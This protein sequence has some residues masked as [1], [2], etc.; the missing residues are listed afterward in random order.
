MLGRCCNLFVGIN[1]AG[2]L[3]VCEGTIEPPDRHPG[4]FGHHVGRRI[5]SLV[6]FTTI[7]T[8]KLMQV[9]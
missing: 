8:P 2:V 3:G 6:A 1:M 9:L 5:A 4:I 7:A